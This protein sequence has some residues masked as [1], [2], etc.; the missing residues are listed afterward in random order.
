MFQWTL[1]WVTWSIKSWLQS[2]MTRASWTGSCS[3]STDSR[4]ISSSMS[5][6]AFV[7]LFRHL[8]HWDT[9]PKNETKLMLQF[10]ETAT[11]S[12]RI[13]DLFH[14]RYYCRLGWSP[15]EEYSHKLT[16]CEWRLFGITSAGYSTGQ[17]FFLLSNQNG[18]ITEGTVR[19]RSRMVT[20]LAS[21]AEGPGFKSWFSHLSKNKVKMKDCD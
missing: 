2:V 17:V 7:Y 3:G 5:L 11:F 16:K 21:T 20:V 13:T 14:C 15:I 9:M 1:W 18:Q 12:F 19:L 4:S 8:N 6:L 10:T